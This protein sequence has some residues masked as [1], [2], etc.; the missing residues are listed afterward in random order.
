M[1][2]KLGLEGL[3]ERAVPA[4]GIT[5]NDAGILRVEGSKGN[6]Y[7][8]VFQNENKVLTA[9][10]KTDYGYQVVKE[11]EISKVKVIQ[12][13]G[14]GGQDSY[15]NNTNFKSENSTEKDGKI[16]EN[17]VGPIGKD[18]P[19]DKDNGKGNDDKEDFKKCLGE[20]TFVANEKG[21]VKLDFLYDGG[22]YVGEMGIYSLKG[23][24]K[25]TPGSPEYIKEAARRVLSSSTQGHLVISD[26]TDA[27]KHSDKLK[28]DGLF[29]NGTYKGPQTFQMEKKAEFGIVLIPN[30]TFW[31]VHNNPNATGAKR[32]LFS[33][34]KANPTTNPQL[35]NIADNI[36]G[37]EDQRLDSNSDKDYNDIVFRILGAEAEEA[38]S[39]KSVA[40]PAKN[41][42]NDPAYKNIVV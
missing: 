32:A 34:E 36:F 29:N 2:T 22:G 38:A 1:K 7:I 35:A 25:L 8:Q 23:M 40:N 11:F 28:T 20:G 9:S 42:Y 4:A 16:Y 31:E 24:S 17:F 10:L 3:E 6:D 12:V 14:K 41:I 19:D 15:F 39:Y 21:V 37:W 33:N 27:A 26:F 13:V 30:G 18:S 5:L